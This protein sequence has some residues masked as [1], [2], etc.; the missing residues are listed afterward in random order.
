M[1]STWSWSSESWNLLGL[2]TTAAVYLHTKFNL[3]EHQAIIIVLRTSVIVCIYMY[4][5][6]VM[7]YSALG[8]RRLQ[9]RCSFTQVQ[10]SVYVEDDLFCYLFYTLMLICNLKPLEEREMRD[11]QRRSARISYIRP[12]AT[13]LQNDHHYDMMMSARDSRA[14]EENCLVIWCSRLQRFVW[15]GCNRECLL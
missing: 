10:L 1:L 13:L 14:D 5:A 3:F 9:Y 2:V 8:N 6:L 11:F 7:V 12:A 15:Y 4:T